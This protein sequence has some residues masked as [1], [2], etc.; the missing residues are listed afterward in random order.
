MPKEE[1]RE[2]LGR[3]MDSRAF[4]SLFQQWQEEKT[5]RVEA[6]LARSATFAVQLSEKQSAVLE[7]MEIFYRQCG[8]AAPL[9]EDVSREIKAPPDAVSALL[10]LG[11][12][13]GKFVRVAD[14]VYYD[15]QTV[16]ALQQTL[17][18]MAQKTGSVT[19]AAFRD[20]TQTNR[21]FAMQALEY[22]DKI[23]FTRRSG[24]ERTLV[25]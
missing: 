10:K 3:D 5:I 8:I 9:I 25:E 6:N 4:G 12:A 19:V 20:L 16:A 17:R 15:A 22:F 7:R 2:A 13:H 23:R 1:L 14:G 24:D 18:E 11:T 21:K